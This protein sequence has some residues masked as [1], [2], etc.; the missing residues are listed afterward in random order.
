M[1]KRL[2][3]TG[4]LP[5]LLFVLQSSTTENTKEKILEAL[6]DKNRSINT[7]MVTMQSRERING[8]YTAK[9][10]LFRIIRDPV[11]IYIKQYYPNEGL[12][13]LYNE[14]KYGDKAIVNRNKF[15]WVNLTLDPLSNSMREDNHHSVFKSG[16]HFFVS[17]IEHIHKKYAD[18]PAKG[19][20]Y[21]GTVQYNDRACYKLIFEK[22]DFSYGK[23]VVQQGDNL[24]SL[25]RKF[26]INDYMIY[27]ANK[28]IKSF[29]EL[30]P[31][32]EI[33]V[34]DEYAKRIILYI[35]K[36]RHIPAGTEIYDDKG[37]FHEYIYSDVYIN[38]HFGDDV[39]D[40]EYKEY[41]F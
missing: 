24:E 3:Y 41:G 5:A 16:F 4:M 17:V 1:V 12:E 14:R 6:F 36:D 31:G 13:V 35:E 28:N 21:I 26:M 9:K 30:T 39:F 10:S 25:S 20:K 27:T 23:Y 15:P 32:T 29:K 18:D 8:D 33:K 11:K 2:I 34:P 37:L 19:F 22:P 38:P 7:L 40:K